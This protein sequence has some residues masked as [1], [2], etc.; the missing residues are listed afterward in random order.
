MDE[1]EGRRI[2]RR[3]RSEACKGL[4][5]TYRAVWRP[6]NRVHGLRKADFP[7]PN[8]AREF[9][10]GFLTVESLPANHAGRF[11]PDKSILRPFD[12]EKATVASYYVPGGK[13][14]AGVAAPPF[15]NLLHFRKQLR[16]HPESTSFQ[17]TRRSP[18]A[19][20]APKISASSGNSTF[21][22]RLPRPRRKI[23]PAWRENLNPTAA[24]NRSS[25]KAPE[26]ARRGPPTSTQAPDPGFSVGL[27]N[28]FGGSP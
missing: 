14:R 22:F 12:L 24:A 10:L 3:S 21:S 26:A 4:L 28:D 23:Q 8:R 16:L 9:T 19:R 2:S 20:T 6:P 7:A 13:I 18:F 25:P 17:R 15:A 1:P 27:G 11:L 5:Q